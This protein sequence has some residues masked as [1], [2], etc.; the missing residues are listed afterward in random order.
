MITEISAALSALKT[1]NDLG[2]GLLAAKTLDEVRA[3]TID[4]Q[5]T[6]LDVQSALLETQAKMAALQEEN[7]T[8]RRNVALRE[9][10]DAE[11]SHYVLHQFPTGHYAYRYNGKGAAAAMI[12][13]FVCAKCFR[14]ES[15]HIL[16]GTSRYLKCP[17]C[18]TAIHCEQPQS[19]DDLYAQ[20]N[21]KRRL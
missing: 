8:L 6:V 2:K 10:K 4:L 21:P 7:T 11:R 5:N 12:D 9:A 17:N 19:L 20:T 15:I 18:D 3:R 13:H 1:V 16:Q 14:E